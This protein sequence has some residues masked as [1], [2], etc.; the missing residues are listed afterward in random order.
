MNKYVWVYKYEEFCNKRRVQIRSKCAILLPAQL[1]IISNS[2]Y[3]IFVASIFVASSH[4]RENVSFFNIFFLSFSHFL[5][6]FP[7]SV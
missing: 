3:H 5:F 2:H 7:I 4:T 6:S 1:D